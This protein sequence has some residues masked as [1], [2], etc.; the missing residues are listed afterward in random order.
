MVDHID[1]FTAFL[2]LG[3]GGVVVPAGAIWL[4]L[5]QAGYLNNNGQ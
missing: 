2:V 1:S 4:W 5:R 3:V